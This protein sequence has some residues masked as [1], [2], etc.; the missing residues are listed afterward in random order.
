MAA[1]VYTS[2]H[3]PLAE[4]LPVRS[5]ELLLPWG[6][7]TWQEKAMLKVK[8]LW[9]RAVLEGIWT[10][11]SFLHLETAYLSLGD[12]TSTEASYF[13]DYQYTHCKSAACLI[14]SMPNPC[15]VI[16]L[17][18]Q[19]QIDWLPLLFVLANR[20][21]WIKGLKLSDFSSA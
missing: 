15:T 19:D 1:L 13:S 9:A 16:L 11:Y 2:C 21:E 20:T 8:S 5:T 17:T 4:M 10:H 18:E 6:S 7:H 3:T 12:L 14:V